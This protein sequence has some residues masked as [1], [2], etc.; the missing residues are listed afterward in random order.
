MLT[1]H[2]KVIIDRFKKNPIS[3]DFIAN[4]IDNELKEI[5]IR[6]FKKEKKAQILIERNYYTSLVQEDKKRVEQRIQWA[7]YIISISFGLI[8]FLDECGFVKLRDADIT[9]DPCTIGP[10]LD[11]NNAHA[12]E[13]KQIEIVEQLIK[14]VDARIEI[15]DDV[16]QL[17]PNK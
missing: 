15:L 4:I 7:L 11:D 10:G 17:L 1:T 2:E 5:R 3:C 8:S 12:F 9:N 16:E 13:I 6:V 14:Y